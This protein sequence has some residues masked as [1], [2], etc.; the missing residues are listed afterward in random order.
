[1]SPQDIRDADW[2]REEKSF[3]QWDPSISLLRSIRSHQKNRAKTGGISTISRKLASLRWCFWSIVTGTDI[4]KEA[5]LGG[6]LILPHPN[7]VVIHEKAVIGV[8]CM[9]MQQVTIGQLAD[10]GAPILG[11]NVYIG[12]GAKVL[13][14]ISIGDNV[15]IGANAV[16]L[17]DVPD[18]STAVGVPAKVIKKS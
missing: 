18:N 2:M 7:G 4:S 5:K 12:A 11:S 3:L 10:E 14:D 9:I 1:M 17:V 16:V 13:G 15:S 6:G 8:N